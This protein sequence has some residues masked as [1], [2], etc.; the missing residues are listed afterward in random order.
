MRSRV[1]EER[2]CRPTHIII[3][4]IAIIMCSSSTACAKRTDAYTNKDFPLL[5][6]TFLG[7]KVVDTNLVPRYLTVAAPEASWSGSYS[8]FLWWS[9]LNFHLVRMVFDKEAVTAVTIEFLSA[10]AK[11]CR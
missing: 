6:P 10:S 1:E 3:F 4:G 9:H 2:C 11:E 7:A 8:P 5:S